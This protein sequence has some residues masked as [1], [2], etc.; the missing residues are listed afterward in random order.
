VADELRPLIDH[1]VVQ[2]WRVEPRPNGRLRWQS[3]NGVGLV[4]TPD[5]VGYGRDLA[6]IVARL[7]RAGLQAPERAARTRARPKEDH[8][9]ATRRA[10]A[11][12]NGTIT[13]EAEPGSTLAE[14]LLDAAGKVD[15]LIRRNDVLERENAELRHEL[16]SARTRADDVRR[17]AL[18]AVERVLTER[19]VS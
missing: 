13:T 4:F 3:P 18:A 15:A 8:M 19:G 17:E 12:T 9:P 7:H 1:A 14:V 11:P 2:G 16:A 10:S 6:N 5:R